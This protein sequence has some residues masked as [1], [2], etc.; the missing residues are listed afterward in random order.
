[1]ARFEIAVEVEARYMVE[2]EGLLAPFLMSLPP[3][4]GYTVRAVEGLR[5]GSAGIMAE[6]KPAGTVGAE[7]A[8]AER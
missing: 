2:A 1:M 3:G 4:T 5:Q 7:T 8:K 6:S